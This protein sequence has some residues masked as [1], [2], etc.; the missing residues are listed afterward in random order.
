MFEEDIKISNNGNSRMENICSKCSAVL[1]DDADFCDECGAPQIASAV[2]VSLPEASAA[3]KICPRC[4]RVAE[5]DEMFCTSC[6]FDFSKPVTP[7]VA[8][9][10]ALTCPGC[11]KNYHTGDKFCRHCAFDLSSLEEKVSSS[12]F[13]TNCGKPFGRD[14][15]FCRHCSFDL[16]DA[17]HTVVMPTVKPAAGVAAAA[18]TPSFPTPVILESVPLISPSPVIPASV[19]A[20]AAAADVFSYEAVSQPAQQFAAAP[21]NGFLLWLSPI[22]AAIAVVSFFLP[23]LS[24]AVKIFGYSTGGMSFS[25]ADLAKFDGSLWLLPLAGIVS[26]S[27]FFFC[28]TQNKIGASRPVIAVSVILAFV[29]MFFK[30]VTIE[31]QLRQ[32]PDFGL[33]QYNSGLDI[34]PQIGIFGLVLGFIVSLV[35]VV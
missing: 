16:T 30:L 33:S 6:A 27:A 23:W 34:K 20:P 5:P 25:G 3:T 29:F 9:P 17:K 8:A 18:P 35:G 12:Q 21:N 31:Q 11:R 4:N 24:G 22:G 10:A 13:C 1:D 15:H 19:K 26:L 2:S 14:D 28:W 32:V 7:T